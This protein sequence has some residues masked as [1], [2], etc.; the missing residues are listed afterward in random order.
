MVVTVLYRLAGEPT[1]TGTTNFPDLTEDWYKDAV[2]WAQENKIALGDD[3]GHFRPDDD[4]T[5]EEMVTFLYRY[6]SANQYDMTGKG[7]LKTFTDSA[8]VQPYAVEPMT[9]AVGSDIIK[10]IENNQLA[11][12]ANATRA[13]FAAIVYRLSELAK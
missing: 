3:T 5:R 2:V 9:W 1:V 6:A 12:L 10:G 8:S 7:D 13:Q 4:V 11:P